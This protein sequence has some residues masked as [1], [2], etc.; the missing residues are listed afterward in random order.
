[1]ALKLSDMPPALV[2]VFLGHTADA[3]KHYDH[4]QEMELMRQELFKAAGK[5]SKS[6]KPTWMTIQD[7]LDLTVYATEKLRRVRLGLPA[8]SLEE[9]EAFLA[10]RK[11]P[12]PALD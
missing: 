6:K 8:L 7:I 10:T 9:A 2:C 5:K 4:F 12:L 11:P 1:M 3:N